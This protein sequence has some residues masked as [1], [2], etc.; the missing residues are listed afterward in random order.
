MK[1]TTS[2]AILFALTILVFS[3]VSYTDDKDGSGNFEEKKARAIS[4]IDERIQKLQE[5]KTCVS[6]ATDHEAMKKCRASMREY[7]HHEKM[8]RMKHRKDR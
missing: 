6:S 3:R 2:I 4:E 7:R 1:I 8:E 5:A